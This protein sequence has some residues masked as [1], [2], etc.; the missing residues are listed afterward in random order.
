MNKVLIGLLSLLIVISLLFGFADEFDYSYDGKNY[1][2]DFVTPSKL[3]ASYISSSFSTVMRYANEF[4]TFMSDTVVDIMYTF[5]NSVDTGDIVFDDFYNDAVVRAEDYIKNNYN[6]LS[7]Y[8]YKSELNTLTEIVR[9]Y[10][11]FI[12]WETDLWYGDKTDVILPYDII[13]YMDYFGWTYDDVKKISDYMVK[14]NIRHRFD[15]ALYD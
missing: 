5:T 4:V 2:V 6:F 14:N 1:G 15:G 7:R 10:D 12:W 8:F 13:S 3:N 9:G 11:K